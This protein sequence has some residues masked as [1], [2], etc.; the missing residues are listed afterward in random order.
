VTAPNAAQK[1]APPQGVWV[2]ATTEVRT[3]AKWIITVLAAVAGVVFGAGPVV[4]RPSMDAEDHW[5][6][7][8]LAGAAGAAGLIGIGILIW[9]ASRVLV[10]VEM[11]L[12]TLPSELVAKI[13]TDSSAYLPSGAT[14]VE[15]F[16]KNL[17][18]YRVAVND[19]DA[20][21]ADTRADLSAAQKSDDGAA[22]TQA[23]DRIALLEKARPG[24]V[25]RRDL[26][27]TTRMTLLERGSYGAV[28][29]IFDASKGVIISGAVLTG[30]GG[31]AFQLLLASSEKEKDSAAP[32][33]PVLATL[34]RLDTPA[35]AAFWDALDLSSCE[36]GS[37]VPVLLRGGKGTQ[38]EPYSVETLPLPG[39]TPRSF[40][41][42]SDVAVLE[43]PA[44]Q[45]LT[46]TYTTATPS[47]SAT[48]TR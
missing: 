4:S 34:T 9:A 38:G 18:A 39:C 1:A 12:A 47:P 3:T 40:D 43:K 45:K 23:M 7:L 32:S 10:P 44:V 13:A 17:R 22:A 25:E 35:G 36:Q 15:E 24:I 31:M 42:L 21:L 16:R 33:A 26:Y 27:D 46:I 37:V 19:L 20:K 11:T 14:S 41:F 29:G 5:V 28:R 2:T 30:L 6:Q 8:M 48:S